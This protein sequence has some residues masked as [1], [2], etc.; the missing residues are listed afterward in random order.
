MSDIKFYVADVET[1]GLSLDYHEI[2]EIS[3]IRGFDRMQFTRNVK[4]DK[5]ENASY[6]ALKIIGKSMNDLRKGSEKFEV[7]KEVEY[8]LSE[9]NSE[10]THRCLIGHNIAFDRKFLC[11]LWAK[12]NKRFPFDLYLDTVHMFKSHCK[13]Q[14]ITKAKSNL[15]AACE[16]TGIKKLGT[17]HNAKIDTRHT[18]LLWQELSKTEDFL[19]HIKCLPHNIEL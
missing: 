3:I 16:M 12:Y 17:A 4:V 15:T 10:P 7:I 19:D 1:T 8:F 14:G 11:A 18:F 9:D 13:K 2:C 5:V 6:D